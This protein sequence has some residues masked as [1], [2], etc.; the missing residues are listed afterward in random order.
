MSVQN[1]DFVSLCMH[2]HG[3]CCIC[4]DRLEMEWGC[5][6]V[7]GVTSEQRGAERRLCCVF[8]CGLLCSRDTWCY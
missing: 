4:A 3:D 1:L 2:G 7:V 8:E 5:A 6:C